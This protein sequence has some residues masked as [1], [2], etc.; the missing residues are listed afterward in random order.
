MSTQTRQKRI[1]TPQGVRQLMAAAI[2]LV[3][4]LEDYFAG[5]NHHGHANVVAMMLAVRSAQQFVQLGTEA[6]T[7]K[8]S[9]A[10]AWRPGLL[11]EVAQSYLALRESVADVLGELGWG[12]MEADK[13]FLWN[14]SALPVRSEKTSQLL[15]YV[16]Y[17]V[18]R[19]AQRL[20]TLRPKKIKPHWD[21]V[22]L[23]FGDLKLLNYQRRVA[24]KQ[25]AILAALE[26]A[27]WPSHPVRLEDKHTLTLHVTLKRINDKIKNRIIRLQAGGDSKS[28]IWSKKDEV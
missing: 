27:G 13:P 25:A 4:N 18:A 11:P 3:E 19:L 14:S 5:G 7:A 10:K 21:G 28:V 20:A 16:N 24:Y 1:P 17:S 15:D 26:K 8:T 23:W 12:E 22:I 6:D 2:Q 9:A